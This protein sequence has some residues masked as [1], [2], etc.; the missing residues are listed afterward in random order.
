MEQ[1][2]VAAAKATFAAIA[3]AVALLGEGGASCWE[4]GASNLVWATRL[5]RL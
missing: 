2:D 4:G 1:G 5:G 3:P